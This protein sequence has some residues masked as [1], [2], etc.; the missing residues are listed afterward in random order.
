MPKQI[1]PQA[2]I[3]I[4]L[5]NRG[6]YYKAHEP[7][8]LAWMEASDPERVLYQGILQIGLAYYQ[9]SRGNFRGA[10]KMFKRGQKHLDSLMDSFLGVDI[11]QLQEDARQVETKT[12]ELGENLL[13]EL[14]GDL[15]KQVPMID[16]GKRL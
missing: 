7:L 10:L 6:E 9:I 1:H 13:S 11:R 5:F 2:M 4:D 8:E 3:G 15:Y 12:R 16:Q 14:R